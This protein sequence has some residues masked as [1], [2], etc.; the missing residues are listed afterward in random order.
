MDAY[1]LLEHLEDELERSATIP[2]IGKSLIEKEQIL[3]IV[4]EIRLKLPDELKQAKWVKVER[5]RILLEA[6]KE[7]EN[8]VQEAENRIV[9]LIDDHEVT[10]LAKQ[11]ADDIIGIANE[12]AQEIINNA[13]PVAEEMIANAQR[14]AKEMNRGSK[15]YADEVLA[16]LEDVLRDALDSIRTD[17]EE[18]RHS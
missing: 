17:R 15:E 2:I 12:T 3:D 6:Q 4:K 11:K 9:T 10:K 18:L 16:K 1:A 14:I 5:H 8:V 13:K 7:A